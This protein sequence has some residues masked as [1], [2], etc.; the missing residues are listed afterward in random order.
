MEHIP[1]R[2]I[3]PTLLPDDIQTKEDREAFLSKVLGKER[4][5]AL[6]SNVSKYAEEKDRP[7]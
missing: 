1:F 6:Q 5:M 2:L 3:S 7:M 4:F